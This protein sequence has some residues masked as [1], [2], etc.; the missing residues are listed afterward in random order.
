MQVALS[1]G[2]RLAA[3]EVLPVDGVAGAQGIGQVNDIGRGQFQHRDGL[4]GHG[5]LLFKPF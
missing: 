1:P 5:I 2:T 3:A 4:G